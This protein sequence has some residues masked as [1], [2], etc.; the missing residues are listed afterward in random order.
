MAPNH[1]YRVQRGR[2]LKILY[3]AFS[4]G[5]HKETISLTLKEM[6]LYATDGILRAHCDYLA[7]KGYIEID[8]N[9][10]DYSDYAARITTKGIDLLE[11]SIDADPGIEL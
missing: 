11:Q 3:K 5:V 8:G 6:H 10:L 4:E 7:E 2:I 9:E 1:E